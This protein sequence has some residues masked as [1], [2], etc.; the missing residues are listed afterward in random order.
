[1]T[2]ALLRW[3]CVAVL[4]LGAAI[5]T[6]PSIWPWADAVGG[7]PHFVI[8][9]AYFMMIAAVVGLCW[10]WFLKQRQKHRT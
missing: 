9:I 8:P 3:L 5:L 6:F 7:M 1:M 10:G 2:S 4:L